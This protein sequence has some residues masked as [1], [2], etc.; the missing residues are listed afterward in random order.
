MTVQQA[1]LPVALD[2]SMRLVFCVGNPIAQIKSPAALTARLAALGAKS[3]VLPA[4][5]AAPDLGRYFQGAKVM[6]NL[7]ALLMTVP[8]KIA[9]LALCDDL[10][11]RARF[12]GAV[13]VM[14]RN[15]DGRWQG[16]NFDGVG[17]FE[18][19]AKGGGQVAGGRVLLV[20]AGGAGSAIAYEILCNGAALLV[21]H[22][23]DHVRRDSLVAR[24]AAEFPRKVTAG[25]AGAA[26]FDIIVNAS[27]CGMAGDDPL[28]MDITGLSAASFVADVMTSPEITPLVA[29]ARERGCGTVVG[30]EMLAAQIDPLARYIL[31]HALPEGTGKHS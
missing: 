19:I 10:S 4:W 18:A 25:N 24:L 31:N 17:M 11:P 14:R 5:V 15:A 12:V 8:H 6:R 9:A 13:N 2:G 1:V 20:G 26:S 23:T 27:P 22:D 3:L 21:I 7:D 16:D 29:A 30:I 28:P